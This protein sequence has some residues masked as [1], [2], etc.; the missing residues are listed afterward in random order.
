[1]NTSR[2]LT[3]GITCPHCSHNTPKTIAWLVVH[4][5]M[6]CA[7]CVAVI[8][9]QSGNDAIAIQELAQKCT[10]L[11]TTFTKSD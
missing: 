8:N 2:N 9:L 7:N 5:E 11:D 3:Y 4:N 10:S 6:T 1:M